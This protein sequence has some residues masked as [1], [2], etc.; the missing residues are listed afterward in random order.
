MALGSNRYSD[1]TTLIDPKNFK[2]LKRLPAAKGTQYVSLNED[3]TEAYVSSRIAGAFS[4]YDLATM[5]EVARKTGFPP[6]DQAIYVSF[7]RG[8]QASSVSESNSRK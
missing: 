2:A 7:E 1:F 8:I 3:F 4:V 6:I 5:R